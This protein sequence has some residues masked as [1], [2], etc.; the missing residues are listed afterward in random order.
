MKNLNFALSI[1][2]LLAVGSFANAQGTFTNS[3]SG[4]FETFGFA[5]AA[6][7][8]TGSLADC[9]DWLAADPN[10]FATIDNIEWDVDVAPQGG[11]WY[12]EAEV[13]LFVDGVAGTSI[14][15]LP[16]DTNADDGTIGPLNSTGS[17]GPLGNFGTLDFE[18][19][20]TFDDGGEAVQDAIIT[21]SITVTYTHGTE[22]VPEPAS[23]ILLAGLGL[24]LIRRRR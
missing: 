1:C 11:S 8:S 5:G 3:V 16:N 6:G 17:T 14:Q 12:S 18:F 19:F 10:N 4:P 9:L 20:E 7:N 23:A 22:V 2:L 13:Q 15:F 24:G 21:G